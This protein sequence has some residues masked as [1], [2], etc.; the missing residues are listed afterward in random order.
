MPK[1]LLTLL[2]I[3]LALSAAGTSDAWARDMLKIN[4]PRRS[5]LTPVQRLNREGVD[6][7]GKHQYDRAEALFYKAYLYDPSDPFTLNNLG[8]IS[9]LNG[10]LDRA[11]GAIHR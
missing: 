1:T 7:V 11:I 4:I 10:Q 8:D 5:E 3:A 6:A 2:A 9:D